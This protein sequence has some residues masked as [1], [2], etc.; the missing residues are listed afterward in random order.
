MTKTLEIATRFKQ[1]RKNKKIS[2]QNLSK[3][4]GVSYG[5]IRRFEN[6]GEISL[7]SLVK[8]LEPIGLMSEIDGLFKTSSYSSFDEIIDELI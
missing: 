1:I 8:L 6:T 4:S 5:S 3:L 2:Q 7:S